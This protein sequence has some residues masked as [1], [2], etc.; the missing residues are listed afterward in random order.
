MRV[1]WFE[2]HFHFHYLRRSVVLSPTLV[3]RASFRF[4]GASVRGTIFN[5]TVVRSSQAMER[6]DQYFDVGVEADARASGCAVRVVT[7][8]LPEDRVTNTNK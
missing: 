3:A 2:L 5:V 6:Q 1:G 4:Q 8:V 7:A